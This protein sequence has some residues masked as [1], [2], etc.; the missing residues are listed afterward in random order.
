[1]RDKIRVGGLV[2]LGVLSACLLGLFVVNPAQMVTALGIVVEF[3]VVSFL[4][5]GLVRTVQWAAHRFGPH[6]PTPVR[7]R[8]RS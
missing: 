1:M 2:A 4:V 6:E 7:A 3:A 5:M 8:A